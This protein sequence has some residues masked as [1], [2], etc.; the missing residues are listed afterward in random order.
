MHATG[1]PCTWRD[2]TS[3]R[4]V[5][6]VPVAA[7]SIFHDVTAERTARLQVQEHEA[8]LRALFESSDH[9]FWTVD[10]DLKLTSY[11]SG[12][13]QMIERI[14]GA[15]PEINKDPDRPRKLFADKGYH[16]FWATKYAEAFAGDPV[17]FETDLRDTK[18]QRVCNEIFLSPVFA[19]D[20]QVIEVFG[21]GHE[22]TDKVM[23][24][25]LVREQAA[26]LKAIFDSSANMMIWT[27]DTDFRITSCNAH[28]Q[29]S[30]EQD[31]GI[32]LGVGDVFS[33]GPAEQTAGKSIART[34]DH[35]KAAL[36]GKPQQFEVE[37]VDL[38]G[39]TIWVENFINP[40]LVRRKGEGT[41]RPGLR[42][43]RTERGPA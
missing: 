22:I 29:R 16:D 31:F 40:I 23:A 7:R 10:R 14:Y 18:G 19:A 12:Y 25:D 36:K 30:A 32:T 41:L 34:F 5:D 17:R 35:Y 33:P 21:V 39:R 4:T 28:F 9:L 26:R 6:G 2:T 42:H 24:E 20:G 11:N 8:K 13:G 3:V 15:R 1:A 38:H 37:L 43:H 27:M